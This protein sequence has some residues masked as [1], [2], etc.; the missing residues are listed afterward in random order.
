MKKFEDI[1]RSLE[2]DHQESLLKLG[3]DLRKSNDVFD[4]LKGSSFEK[5]KFLDHKSFSNAPQDTWKNRIKNKSHL[6]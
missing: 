6:N 4:N 3:Q 5:L 2:V 1:S